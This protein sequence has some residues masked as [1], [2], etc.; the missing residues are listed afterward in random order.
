VVPRRLP[1]GPA[2]TEYG[3]NWVVAAVVVRLPALGR[4]VAIAVLAR[5]VIKGTSPR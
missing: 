3:N 5:L 2:K 4:P 1:A